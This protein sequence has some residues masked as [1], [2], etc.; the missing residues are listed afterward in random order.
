MAKR[1]RE[2]GLELTPDDA[3]CVTGALL[4]MGCHMGSVMVFCPQRMVELVF[5]QRRDDGCVHLQR[6]SRRSGAHEG[7]RISETINFPDR[8]DA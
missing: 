5:E 6:V 7:P 8:D 3:E 2:I 1:F 4:H